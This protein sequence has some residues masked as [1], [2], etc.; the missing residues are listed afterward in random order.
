MP[1]LRWRISIRS[2]RGEVWAHL[3][4]FER[5]HAWFLGVRR[6][7]LLAAEPS[8]GAE[9]VLRLISGASHRERIIRWEPPERLS[10]VVLD[11]VIAGRDWVA[12]IA[13]RE[14][15]AATELSWELRYEPRFGVAG[16]LLDRLLVQP[17]LN[18]VFRTS[19][20]RLRARVEEQETRHS[21]E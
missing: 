11:P 6:M 12:D 14:Q 16:R 4:D 1:Q 18:I 10:I 7:S 17:V 20:R 15:G 3:V 9:R 2:T 21:P 5:M 8:R 13:L 19:L